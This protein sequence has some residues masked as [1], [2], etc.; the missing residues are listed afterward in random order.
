MTMALDP[1]RTVAELKELRALTG[2]ENGA[3]RVAFTPTWVKAREWLGGKLADL[4][5]ET[6]VI[7]RD[8]SRSRRALEVR[9]ST[10]VV[11][12]SRVASYTIKP[13]IWYSSA[14]NGR[15]VTA[16]SRRCESL[17]WING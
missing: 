10:S 7:S 14:R 11:G 3:Q 17:C 13:A 4:P 8:I 5:V 16:A 1:Q 12:S 2:D 15:C 9:T 6:H